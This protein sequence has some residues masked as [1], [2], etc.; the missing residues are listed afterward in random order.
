MAST[1]RSGSGAKAQVSG[2]P[3]SRY[4]VP[5]QRA[6]PTQDPGASNPVATL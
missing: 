2:A 6:A 1:S 4:P 3:R 5:S